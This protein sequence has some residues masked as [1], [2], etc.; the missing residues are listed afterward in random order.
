MARVET[1]RMTAEEFWE[2]A[3][4]QDW[5]SCRYELRGG[6]VVT[7]RLNGVR[8]GVVCARVAYLLWEQVKRRGQGMAMSNNT[9]LLTQR[10]PDT[11]LGP[12][13]M[14]FER[15]KW[16][17]ELS[18]G[19]CEDVPTLAVEVLDPQDDAAA[20]SWRVSQ[21]RQPGV[22]LVWV[23]DP[24]ERTVVVHS[25]QGSRVCGGD[26]EVGDEALIPGLRCRV[27]ELFALPGR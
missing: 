12:D 19:F 9:A 16:L 27:A 4:D 1:P 22:P 13:L 5:D 25:Q 11:L 14:Y 7:F 26:D 3:A 10:G 20:T 6:H 15:G 17:E 24:E 2:W 18:D 21:Y 8:H 23:I